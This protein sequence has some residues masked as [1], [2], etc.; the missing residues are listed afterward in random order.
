MQLLLLPVT[1]NCQS[2]TTV[3]HIQR[4]TIDYVIACSHRRHGQDKTVLSCLQLCSHHRCG[5]DKTVLSCRCWRCEQAIMK[6]MASHIRREKKYVNSTRCWSSETSV[7]AVVPENV[8]TDEPFGLRPP[9]GNIRQ[10]HLQ[11]TWPFQSHTFSD[12]G[13]N[14]C[15][16]KHSAPYWSN[17]PIFDFLTLPESQK[18]WKGCKHLFLC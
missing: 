9:A 1:A 10:L 3:A 6:Q 18:N 17:P 11:N 8:I 12:C 14:E 15:K 16:P 4:S 2:N 13:K 5:Q 7:W